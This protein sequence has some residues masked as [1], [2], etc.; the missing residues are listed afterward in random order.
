MVGT[1]LVMPINLGDNEIREGGIARIGSKDARRL[2]RHAL[3]ERDIV[4]S[5][6]GDV[7]RRSIVRASQAGW[8]CGT[9]CLAA[10]FGNKQ[11]DVNPAYVAHYLASTAAQSWLQDNA[12]GGTMPNLNT[13]IL[14]ALPVRLPGRAEQDQIVVALDD[15]QDVIVKSE[16]LIAK[17]RTIKQAMMQQLLTGRTRLPGFHDQWV[18]ASFTEVSTMKGRIGWQGLTQEE[19]TSDAR[20]PFLITGMNFKDGAINW[21]EVYHV[22]E[23]RYAVAP[24]IQLHPDDVLMTKDGTI[25]KLLYVESIP[26]PGKATLNSHLLVFRPRNNAYVPRYLYYQ[27]ASPRFA[28]HIELHKSGTT[29]F[30]ISQESVGK[31]QVL[32]PS[33]AEQVAISAALSDVDSEIDAIQARLAKAQS[34]KAGMMQTLLNGRTRLPAQEAAS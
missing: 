21:N 31:Y 20:Q 14:A 33:I 2:R 27:L 25:G 32:L 12:V 18:E 29:F 3:R 22:S 4:F 7:G 13:G 24:E 1:P 15:V 6:R 16:R 19:F 30:G 10:R 5:R 9:G 23:E 34:V 28:K 8:L 17:K 26:N 11:D